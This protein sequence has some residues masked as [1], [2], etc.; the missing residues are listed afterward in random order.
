MKVRHR[1]VGPVGSS[2]IRAIAT[3][4]QSSCTCKWV[5]PHR[6]T[7]AQAKADWHL[8]VAREAAELRQEIEVDR[9]QGA[10]L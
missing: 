6:V 8:H 3:R 2:Y 10:D 9:D 1:Y 7:R 5:G 4:W